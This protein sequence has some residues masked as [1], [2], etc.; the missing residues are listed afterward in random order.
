MKEIAVIIPNYNGF[1]DLRECLQSLKNQTYDIFFTIIVDNNSSDNSKSIVS[2]FPNTL[3]FGLDKNYGFAKAVNA[4]IKKSLQ[5]KEVKFILLL[6]NDVT[7]KKN[8][9]EEILKPFSKQDIFSVACKMMNYYQRDVID[10]CGDFINK[11]GLPYARGNGEKDLGKYNMKEYIFGACAGAGIYRR[12]VFEKAGF[13]DESFIAY[14][15]DIDLAFRM[16]LMGMKCYYN[17]EAICYH[18]RGGTYGKLKNYDLKMCRRNLTALRIKNYPLFL[19]FKYFPAFITGGIR[20]YLFH[21]RKSQYREMIILFYGFLLGLTR[22][23]DA[24]LKRYKI[25]SNK[26]VLNSYIENLFI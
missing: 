1:S 17:P 7:C 10:D 12:E 11:N 5:Y 24:I 3:W 2:E 19:Y 13:F 6:N 22:I 21:F 25:Q 23:P 15:E 9:I 16:Q 20:R 8:F 14:Y 4:G 18:K 26:A